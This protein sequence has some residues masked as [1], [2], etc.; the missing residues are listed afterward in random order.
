M[1]RFS[2]SP[3]LDPNADHDREGLE[4][5]RHNARRFVEALSH[6]G[7][8]EA[9]F[10]LA[11]AYT[12]RPVGTAN[13]YLVSEDLQMALRYLL[14]TQALNPGSNT[15]YSL[16]LLPTV[17]DRLTPDEVQNVTREAERISAEIIAARGE[18][19]N[20]DDVT[21]LRPLTTGADCDYQ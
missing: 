14:V 7:N 12:G 17:R 18:P 6:A 13:Q 20:K 8:R 1:L 16:A 11:V 2:L 15:R 19:S 3:P 10:A 21:N 5:Y 4:L 9:I